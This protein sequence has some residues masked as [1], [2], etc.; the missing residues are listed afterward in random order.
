MRKVGAPLVEPIVT[1]L[2]RVGVSPNFLTILGFASHISFAWA[3]S[4]GAFLIAGILMFFLTPLDALDGAL[5]RKLKHK[6]NGF[7]AFLDSSL[8]RVGEV[9][10]LGSFILYYGQQGELR[11]QIAAYLAVT[12]S[13]M[14]SYARARAEGLGLDCKIGLFSRAERYFLIWFGLLGSVPHISLVLLSIGSYF[15]FL[16]RMREVYRL[17]HN[18]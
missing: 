10:F 16:Q 12:G 4:Q 13:L 1:L 15:T 9:V 6:Q 11:W 18:E 3:I 14:V 5:S 2:A 8:D 17:T 7:G